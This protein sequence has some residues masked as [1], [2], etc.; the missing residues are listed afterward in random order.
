MY[1]NKRVFMGRKLNA[2]TLLGIKGVTETE[3]LL[4]DEFC[5]L[6]DNG[7]FVGPFVAGGPTFLGGIFQPDHVIF[8]SLEPLAWAHKTLP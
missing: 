6:V 7:V 2:E 8:V 4:R 3:V 5:A 1:D